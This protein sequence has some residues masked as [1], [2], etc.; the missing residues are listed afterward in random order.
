MSHGESQAAKVY[1]NKTASVTNERSIDQSSSDAGQKEFHT[2]EQIGTTV[3]EFE[4]VPDFIANVLLYLQS[5]DQQAEYLALISKW[6]V[7]RFFEE[8]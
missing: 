7:S 4:Y 1:R 8:I 2:L 3:V 5:D 6:I